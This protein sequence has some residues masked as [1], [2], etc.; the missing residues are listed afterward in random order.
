M[1]MNKVASY[2]NQV[3]AELVE[4]GLKRHASCFQKHEHLP[5][6]FNGLMPFTFCWCC[7]SYILK[8]L[9]SYYYMLKN[10]PF[11]LELICITLV[12]PESVPLPR[13]LVIQCCHQDP[14]VV[15]H[16]KQEYFWKK[17]FFNPYC[18]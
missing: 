8:R 10:I 16:A 12:G 9:S 5:F 4:I 11:K 15:T 3:E 1:M 7:T 18:K 14:N 17:R 13:N 6:C 2:N